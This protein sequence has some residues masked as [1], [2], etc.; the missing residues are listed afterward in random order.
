LEAAVL[1][2]QRLIRHAEIERSAGFDRAPA[3]QG[4]TRS[5]SEELRGEKVSMLP[6]L[7][8][9]CVPSGWM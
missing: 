9:G 2:L 7:R 6:S 1:A 4:G 8:C 3:R 5:L